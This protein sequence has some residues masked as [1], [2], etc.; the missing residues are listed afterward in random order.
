MTDA[1]ESYKQRRNIPVIVETLLATSLP[2][3]SR[4]MSFAILL[5][6]T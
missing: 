6:E 1:D 3:E 5:A 2:T 4:P